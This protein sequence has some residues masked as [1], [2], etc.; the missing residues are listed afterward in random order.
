M[1]EMRPDQIRPDEMNDFVGRAHK[2]GAT[3][4]GTFLL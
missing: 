1:D 2:R 4:Q 3:A